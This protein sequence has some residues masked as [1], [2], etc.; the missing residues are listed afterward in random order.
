[1]L[2]GLKTS[3][4]TESS[5]LEKERQRIAEE[6]K[7]LEADRSSLAAQRAQMEE[8]RRLEEEKQRIAQ[9]QARIRYERE[10]LEKQ[11]AEAVQKT[12][13]PK[14]AKT[15]GWMGISVQ[16]VS[17]NIA[18]NL[19]LKERSGSLIFE[20]FKGDPAD[21]AGLQ[22]GDVVIEVNGTRIKDSHQLLI[23]IASFHV[24]E[25][26]NIKILRDSQ[27]KTFQVTVA[28]RKDKVE[29]VV[30]KG[31]WKEGFGMTVQDITPQIAQQMDIPR[32]KGVIVTDVEGG[33][34]ADEVGIR[35]RDIILQVN[36]VPTNS[37][38][39]YQREVSMSKKMAKNSILFLIK[40]GKST[41]YV[42]L[43]Q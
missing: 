17:E 31:G 25:K 41:F 1:M 19:K 29:V 9:E 14:E 5:D 30:E 16:D 21:K 7:R 11:Q 26:V 36:K 10:D 13:Q 38:Q 42:A 37:M 20:V 24:G 27:E 32:T 4:S 23:I 34:P 40:R 43:R 6:S 3:P 33:S 15:R 8:Q 39:V 18:K 22:P 28:E 12:A 35:P 2:S